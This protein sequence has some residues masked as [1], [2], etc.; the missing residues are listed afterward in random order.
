M[1]EIEYNRIL[2]SIEESCSPSELRL[3]LSN[4]EQN[5]GLFGKE[6]TAE[7][8]KLVNDKLKTFE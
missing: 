6:Q 8:R 1:D 3:E 5:E 2:N 4:I 7:L